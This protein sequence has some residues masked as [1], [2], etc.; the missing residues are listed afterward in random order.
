MYIIDKGESGWW[1]KVE[2]G[3]DKQFCHPSQKLTIMKKIL[4]LYKKPS[5]TPLECLERWRADNP[6]YKDVKMTYAGR[7]D[8]LAEGELLILLGDEC[9]NKEKYLNLDKEYE[10]DILFGF[11]TDT[12]DILGLPAN[13]LALQAL[14]DYDVAG[15]QGKVE[16]FLESIKGKQT[17]KYPPFSS[18]TVGGKQLFELAKTGKLR[19]EEIPER[20]IEIYETEFIKSHCLSGRDLKSEIFKKILAVRGDFRQEETLQKWNEIL[21]EHMEEQFLV[22]KIRIRCSAGTYV[23]V[24]ANNLGKKIGIGALAL[25]IKR[26]KI[27]FP[28]K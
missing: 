6:R 12:H 11:A 4:K 28:G 15:H 16:R 8:P 19:Q 22:S 24:I 9:K 2:N 10:F 18:K 3:R 25:N 7:L 17:Q 1:K 5:E 13:H 26:T 14:S 21:S 23:R 20:E 27:Y